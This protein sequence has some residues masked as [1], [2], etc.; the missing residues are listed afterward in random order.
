[1]WSNAPRPPQEAPPDSESSSEVFSDEKY[2]FSSD[3]DRRKPDAVVHGPWLPRED[4]PASMQ[5]QDGAFRATTQAEEQW[6]R[7]FPPENSNRSADSS[8]EPGLVSSSSDDEVDSN[9][10]TRREALVAGSNVNTT[11]DAGIP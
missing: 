3:E 7:Y 6:P 5:P 4:L 9:V 10:P 11:R 1:M 2:E 8:S